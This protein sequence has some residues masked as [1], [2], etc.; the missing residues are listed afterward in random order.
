MSLFVSPFSPWVLPLRVVGVAVFLYAIFRMFAAPDLTLLVIALIGSL[1]W[2]AGTVAEERSRLYRRLHSTPV[3]DIMRTL[4]VRARSWIPV[5][6]FRS[7]HPALGPDAFIITTQDGYDAGV[8]TPEELS[9]V[10]NE[11]A[12][13][14]P[15]AHLARPLSY[16]QALREDDPALEAF[17]ELKRTQDAFLPVLKGGGALTGIVTA[18]HID[19]WLQDNGRDVQSPLEMPAEEPVQTALDRLA[20]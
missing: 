18:Q 19:R 17:L 4:P 2:Q 9:A 15:L 16:V 3:K 1:L 7:D 10:P 12:R 8:L 20:A 14:T 13:D 11:L 6:R 5:L